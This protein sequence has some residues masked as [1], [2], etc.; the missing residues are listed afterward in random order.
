MLEKSLMQHYTTKAET[1]GL[2]HCRDMGQKTL[3]SAQE[4]HVSNYMIYFRNKQQVKMNK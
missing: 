2:G 4:M 3:K 1:F